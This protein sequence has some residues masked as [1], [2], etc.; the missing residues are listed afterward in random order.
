ME[1]E[2]W[3]AVEVSSV[4]DENDVTRAMRRAALLRRA[5]RPV[6]PAV[7]GERVDDRAREAPGIARV[8]VLEDGGA[9][10]WESALAAA[11]DSR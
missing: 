4:V 11:L 7:A 9:H 2:I 5:G 8:L 10:Q 6:V 1:Y 3:I